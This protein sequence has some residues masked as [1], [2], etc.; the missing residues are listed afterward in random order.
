LCSNVKRS[1]DKSIKRNPLITIIYYMI[2]CILSKWILVILY[3]F[4]LFQRHIYISLY[5]IFIY[6]LFQVISH[7]EHFCNNNIR[8]NWLIYF[9]VNNNIRDNW[10]I[11]FNVN[12]NIYNFDFINVYKNWWCIYLIYHSQ[13]IKFI[14]KFVA[15]KVCVK[16]ITN[17]LIRKAQ[18]F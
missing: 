17:Y 8:D 14:E 12:F 5:N 16:L 15:W 3:S 9:N 4:H 13:D 1:R 7:F 2:M 10:L 11:Y 18:W 6:Y